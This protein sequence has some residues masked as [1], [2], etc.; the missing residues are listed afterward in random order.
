MEPFFFINL[1]RQQM[2]TRFMET[3]A[4]DFMETHMVN[5]ISRESGAGKLFNYSKEGHDV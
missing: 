3:V 4:G 5:N 1:Y 2:W